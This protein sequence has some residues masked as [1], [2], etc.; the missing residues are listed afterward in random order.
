MQYN[1]NP[2]YNPAASKASN[3]VNKVIITVVLLIFILAFSLYEGATLA[4]TSKGDLSI[5]QSIII[6]FV[7]TSLLVGIVLYAIHLL[8]KDDHYRNVIKPQLLAQ[9]EKEERERQEKIQRHNELIEVQRRTQELL[10]QNNKIQESQL[11]KQEEQNQNLQKVNDEMIEGQ[12]KT[13]ELLSQNNQIQETQLQKQEEQNQNLLMANDYLKETTELERS[14]NSLLS[15]KNENDSQDAETRKEL[16]QMLQTP[17]DTL[18]IKA[19]GKRAQNKMSSDEKQV[20]L[21][22]RLVGYFNICL[23]EYFTQEQATTFAYN[24]NVIARCGSLDE[25]QRI[26]IQCLAIDD[27]FHIAWNIGYILKQNNAPYPKTKDYNTPNR[28]CAHLCAA[29]FDCK[30]TSISTIYSNLHD[31]EKGKN[32][33]LL[34]RIDPLDFPELDTKLQEIG[35]ILNYKEK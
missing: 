17:L 9:R 8:R 11:D 29:M 27:F 26:E 30:D 7:V 32:V 4:D 28:Y 10:S 18:D 34:D 6:V 12:R 2:D 19:V 1:Q 21:Y 31:Y 23:S 5:G 33:M 3:F 35:I 22:K 15:K 13:Q 20:N 24:M 16:V 14:N 25:I